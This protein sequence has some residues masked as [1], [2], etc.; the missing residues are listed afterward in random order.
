MLG[1]SAI[2]FYL[3]VVN[4]YLF[5]L[6]WLDRS[7]AQQKSWRVPNWQFL[8]LGLVGGGIG[9]LAGQVFL[10]HKTDLRR[11]SLIFQIGSLLALA[12]ILYAAGV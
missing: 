4:V 5:F 7:Q 12:L 6:I 2:P 8:V 1:S 11:Y 3:I 9:G 10:E